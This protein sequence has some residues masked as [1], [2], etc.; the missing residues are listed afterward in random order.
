MVTGQKTNR[1]SQLSIDSLA[2]NF[3]FSGIGIWQLLVP[4]DEVESSVISV[5]ESFL[6]LFGDGTIG[7][8]MGLRE[9]V[10]LFVHP[11]EAQALLNGLDEIIQGRDDYFEQNIRLMSLNRGE[12]RWMSFSGGT[13]E[14]ETEPG[15]ICLSGIVTDIHNN[16]LAR[17]ALTDALQARDESSR[18]LMAEQR[19]LSAVMDAANVGVFSLDLITME[20]EYSPNCAQI[21]GRDVSELGKTISERE[22]L[23]FEADRGRTMKA[24]MDHCSGLTP[25]YESVIRMMHKDGSA[26]WV[27]DKGQVAERDHDGRPTRILGVM[28]NVTKQ[29]RIEEDLAAKKEQMELFF[30]AA[31]FGA[32]DYD[33]A[34]DLLDYNDIFLDLLGLEPGDLSGSLEEWMQLIHPEDEAMVRASTNRLRRPPNDFMAFEVRLRRKDG[35]YLWTYDV[36]RVMVRNED[37]APLRVVGGHFDFSS[38]KKM[39]EEL[40]AI[41]EQEREARLA[42]KLAEESGRAKSEFLANMS[43]EIRTPM[44]AIQG[45]THLVL[46]TDLNDQQFEYLQRISVAT[47]ALLRIINDILDFSK[48]EAGKLEMEKTCFN[49][50]NLIQASLALHQSQAEAKSLS[51]SLDFPDD[52][53]V[54]LVGDPVR[55]GQ[56]IN[57]L[58]SNALKFTEKGDIAVSV[59]LREILGTHAHLQFSV[60]DSGIGMSPEQRSQLFRAFTQ[61]DASITRRYGGTG[62]GLTISKRLA[63]MMGGSIWCE[64]RLGE[65]SSFIFTVVLEI[66]QPPKEDKVETDVSFKGLKALVI[67]DNQTALEIIKVALAQ[68]EME[69]SAFSSGQAAFEH[70]KSSSEAYDLCLIDWKMPDMDGLETIRLINDSQVM[71]K[72]TVIVMVTAYDRDEVLSSA[73]EVGAVKVLTKPFSNNLLHEVLLELFGKKASPKPTSRK[74]KN[75]AEA[76]REM[77][78]GIQGSKILLVED[79]D[80]NQLVASKILSNAGFVVSIAANG[81]KA[82]DMVSENDYSLV[83]MDVQMPVM[84]GLSAT[85]IIR[86]MGHADLPIVAMT[87]HAMSNDRQLSLDAGMND[88]IS[89]PIN[90]NEL[91]QTLVKWI[92]EKG[93]E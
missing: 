29:K 55:L 36:G 52:V 27:L 62:L 61:A 90:V 13:M 71:N 11:E 21:L 6:S 39:E 15:E 56:I 93:T 19:R 74:R 1:I 68:E 31:N 67:D 5:N 40:N 3:F 45:L 33:V 77:V 85:R 34:N 83:L 23:V 17:L 49:L 76:E 81:Q 64:S 66:G 47:Q 16:R 32:W 70:L 72:K 37:G 28:L 82:V 9:F 8:V 65:G 38:R 35:T 7:S 88:H 87:A 2:K 60:K 18:A 53:P 25:Q 84:D 46:Q 14:G 44:N 43:H 63:E 59:L 51:L 10:G 78:K 79:N 91:L 86:E 50:H 58:L 80:V 48:I 54:H 22:N 41:A 24:V 73:R 42:Q 69:V 92:P 89:K 26:V 20:A 4:T 57:N 12:Y 30:K 75:S